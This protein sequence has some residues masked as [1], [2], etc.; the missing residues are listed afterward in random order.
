[1]KYIAVFMFIR[2]CIIVLCDYD[3]SIDYLNFPGIIISYPD[4]EEKNESRLCVPT[5]VLRKGLTNVMDTNMY[6]PSKTDASV[7]SCETKRGLTN[8]AC[9]VLEGKLRD[10]RE[11]SRWN[12]SYIAKLSEFLLHRVN[13]ISSTTISDRVAN[14]ISRNVSTMLEVAER[15]DDWDFYGVE[16]DIK[17]SR[18]LLAN[19]FSYVTINLTQTN[20]TLSSALWTDFVQYNDIVNV[21]LAKNNLS[22][23]R[24]DDFVGLED[25]VVFLML[26]S[27]N[28]EHVEEGAFESLKRLCF[29]DLK[30]NK[31]HDVKDNIFL[32]ST[33]RGLDLSYNFVRHVTPSAFSSL[34]S[35]VALDLNGNNLYEMC[36][37]SDWL[38][39]VQFLQTYTNKNT[40]GWLQYQLIATQ[41][42]L[43]CNR[44]SLCEST[45]YLPT[46]TEYLNLS[47][48]EFKE[49]PTFTSKV[50]KTLIVLSLS[51][52]DIKTIP[53]GYFDHFESLILLDISK[54]EI[55]EMVE[56]MFSLR[57]LLTLLLLLLLLHIHTRTHTIH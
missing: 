38:G 30:L 50:A 22:I 44:L 47:V 42:S 19:A 31:L 43:G 51:M 23:I 32:S 21:E 9:R 35:L 39:G 41:L 33:L 10:R 53:K 11:Y 2:L 57:L 3:D 13:N 40:Q 12:S 27:N 36:E 17:I 18:S 4:S 8:E 45:P 34:E 46:N 20:V 56:G 16:N 1:M 15:Y 25:S 29:L 24:N 52:N 28:I 5:Y 37:S 55:S 7:L 48:S 49:M 14:V 54:N 6:N 26:H